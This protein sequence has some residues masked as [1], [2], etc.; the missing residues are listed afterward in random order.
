MGRSSNY[1]LLEKLVS[2]V[3]GLGRGILEREGEESVS[4]SQLLTF[5]V[6][7]F[8]VGCLMGSWRPDT[9]TEHFTTQSGTIGHKLNS[10]TL[11][12]SCKSQYVLRGLASACKHT[13]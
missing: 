12:A 11:Q 10:P 1:S 4:P 3:L 5:L 2:G 9:S 13:T 7:T 8:D 6:T